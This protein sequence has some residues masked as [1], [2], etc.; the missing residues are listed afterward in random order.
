MSLSAWTIEQPLRMKRS[1]TDVEQSLWPSDIRG[2]N[3]PHPARTSRQLNLHRRNGRSARRWMQAKLKTERRQLRQI[4]LWR[5]PS[6]VRLSKLRTQGPSLRRVAVTARRP[7]PGT[8]RPYRQLRRV[9]LCVSP[10]ACALQLEE[11]SLRPEHSSCSPGPLLQ[12]SD[13]AGRWS[14]A[15]TSPRSTG[16]DAEL[17]GSRKENT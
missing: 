12:N 7:R 8:E 15:H 9:A 13:V 3:R 11:Y 14:S 1:A 10:H 17:R 2:P 16:A 6:I 5:H 4:A